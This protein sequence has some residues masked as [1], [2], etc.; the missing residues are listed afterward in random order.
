MPLSNVGL[1]TLLD[2]G[3]DGTGSHWRP[4]TF[5]EGRAD[6]AL[7]ALTMTRPSMDSPQQA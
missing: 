6:E 1:I 5:G 3:S 4:P 7:V 2:C